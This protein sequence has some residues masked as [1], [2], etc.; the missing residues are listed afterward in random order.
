MEVWIRVFRQ[1]CDDWRSRRADKIIHLY[2]QRSS[3]SAFLV[4]HRNGYS[5]ISKVK[6]KSSKIFIYN[7][8]T[9]H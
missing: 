8:N 6:Q 1:K 3:S 9:V 2:G 5:P 7:Q 4:S